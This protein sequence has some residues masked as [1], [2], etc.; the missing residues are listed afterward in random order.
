[1]ITTLSLDELMNEIGVKSAPQ[2]QFIISFVENLV[3]PKK[4]NPARLRRNN[5]WMYKHGSHQDWKSGKTWINGKAFSSQGKV[6]EFCQDW[7]S[8][9]KIRE[10]Y[11]KYWKN[12]K[13][14]GKFVSQ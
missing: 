13:K 11:S 4:A 12:Q 5:C 8:L 9:G 7:K 14:L 10:F 3:F 2:K 1:M 6:R